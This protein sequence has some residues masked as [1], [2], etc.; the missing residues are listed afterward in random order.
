[1]IQPLTFAISVY[2]ECASGRSS[3]PVLIL[4]SVSRQVFTKCL[5]LHRSVHL[6]HAVKDEASRESLAGEPLFHVTTECFLC[7]MPSPLY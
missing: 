2:H 7:L 1:M 4:E 6:G 3:Y 5:S